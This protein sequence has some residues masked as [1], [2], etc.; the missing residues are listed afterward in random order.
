MSENTMFM[1]SKYQ[2]LSNII[3]LDTPVNAGRSVVK[4]R[5]QY[6][7][8]DYD[9]KLRI[10]KACMLAANRAK[11]MQGLQDLSYREEQELEEV[12]RIYKA[13][14]KEFYNNLK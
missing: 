11:A 13:A 4:L 10:A 6:V 1:S 5:E 12:H 2:Y 3:R 7:D 9:K 8:A 14:A